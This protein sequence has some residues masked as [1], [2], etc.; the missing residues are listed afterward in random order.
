M[1]DISTFDKLFQG[2]STSAPLFYTFT[3]TKLTGIFL[4]SSHLEAI[5]DTS[6]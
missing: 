6:L 3:Y 2:T 4:D 5:K 1:D